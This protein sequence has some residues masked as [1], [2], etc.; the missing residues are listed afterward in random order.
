MKVL[1]EYWKR[2]AASAIALK[3]K[4]ADPFTRSEVNAILL[5]VLF[6]LLILLITYL[7]FGYLY[8][9][10]IR[11][12]IAEIMTSLSSE[13]P[14]S[15][16]EITESLQVVRTG[17]FKL[18]SVVLGMITVFFL[19]LVAR[20]T[21]R[22]AR[23][24]LNSQKRFVSDIAHELRTPLAV[25]KTNNE[26]AMMENNLDP[27]I[28]GMIE[29]NIEELDRMSQII[30][31][32]LSF[33]NVIRPERVK[34]GNVDMGAVI[35]ASVSKLRN[36][37][38]KRKLEVVV[39][40]VA[41]TIVWGNTVALEQ[42]VSNLL[43]NAINHTPDGGQITIRVGPDYYGNVL[44]YIEDTGDGISKK[45]LLHIFEPFYRAEK[46]RSRKFGSSGLG[47]TIVSELVKMHS[48]RITVKSAENKGTVAIV[49]IPY[50]RNLG[51]E[52]SPDPSKS[53]EISID[54]LREG[55]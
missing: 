43:K 55:E 42:V 4:L 37:A 16:E 14:K 24:A 1:K 49:T 47:L 7:F 12:L 26:V 41:P 52:K 25:I 3:N 31:N 13:T 48:G 29:S 8:E 33:N 17:N 46:S 40:K 45:D 35:D 54:F 23:D 20:V 38:E 22:P 44:T 18:F 11:T 34:F 5:Q 21:L 30:N 10:I 53:N 27:E 9:N 50:G 51:E 39:K 32:V 36:L 28:K 15:V 2:F 6:A 19:F